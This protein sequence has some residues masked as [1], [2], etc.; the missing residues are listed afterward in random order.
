MAVLGRLE[1][2]SES[3]AESEGR[4]TFLEASQRRRA[5]ESKSSCPALL[6]V[7]GRWNE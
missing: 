3:G 7:S 5:D 4:V 6:E 2:A 1:G